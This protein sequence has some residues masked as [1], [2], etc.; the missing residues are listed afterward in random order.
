MK[1]YILNNDNT[2]GESVTEDYLKKVGVLYWHFDPVS[3]SEEGRLDQICKERGYTYR[4]FV[5][6]KS[7]ISHIIIG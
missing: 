1:A 3:F 6:I 2:S 4:D 5:S 7:F